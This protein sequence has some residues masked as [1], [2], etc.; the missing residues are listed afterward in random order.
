VTTAP[1]DVLV[2]GA[3]PTGLTLAAQ[4]LSFG[5]SFRIVDRQLD[6]VHESRALAV[7]PRTLEVLTGLGVADAMVERGNPAVR[8]QMHTGARTTEVPLFDIGLDDTAYPFLL[9]LSQAETEAV[10]A[11]HLAQRGAT[12]ERGVELFDLRQEPDCVACTLRQHSGQTEEVEARYVVGCDGAHS[13]VR[14]RA[15]I[16]FS[17]SAYPQTFVLADLAADGLDPGAAHVYLSGAGM[18]FFFPLAH[19]APWRLLAM[20]PARSQQHSRSGD[21]PPDLAQLQALADTYTAAQVQLRDPVWTTYFRIHHRHATR[22]RSGRLFVAGDAAHVH[23]PAGAQGMNTGIQDAWNL[24]WKLALVADGTANPALLDTYEAERQ[25]VGRYVLRFTD[26][27]FTIATSTNRLVRLLRTH[28][29]PRLIQLAL[30]FARGRA[31]GFRAVSQL[32]INYR[33]SPA[34]Q[35]GHPQLRRGP[36]AGDRLPD[37]PVTVDAKP[38]TLHRALAAAPRFHLL[39]AGPSERWPADDATLLGTRH[40]GLYDTHRLTRQTGPGALVDSDGHAHRRLGLDSTG[41]AAHYLIRPDLHIAYRAAGTDP[42]GLRTYL[43]RW[44][45]GDRATGSS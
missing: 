17:G 37:A 2:V 22:Y 14:D 45:P 8:L 28:V 39:L 13:R 29:A 21:E 4:L 6:R 32:A 36:R 30:G 5:A 38:Q 26:R 9:F 12:V 23:S 25:P 1:T 3:G 31:V 34:V 24:G 7:Q 44:L 35:E 20:Q 11:E 33:D 18:L 10:L 27:A 43:D 16:G 41:H 42:T 19:P 15:G 40:A